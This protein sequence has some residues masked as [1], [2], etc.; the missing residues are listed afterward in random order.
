MLLTII[1]VDKPHLKK[2][3]M[4]GGLPMG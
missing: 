3:G 2:S 1:F 4:H